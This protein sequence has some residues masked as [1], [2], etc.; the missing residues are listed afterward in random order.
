MLI[1]IERQLQDAF[2]ALADS[3]RRNGWPV[4]AIEHGL[5]PDEIEALRIALEADLSRNRGLNRV[6]VLVWLVMAAEV[7]YSYNGDEYWQSFEQKIPSWRDWGN[8]PALKQKFLCFEKAYSGFRPVGRWAEHF[9]IIS[10]P[11]SH[12]IL[13]SALHSK[14]AQ[15]LHDTRF[16]FAARQNWTDEELGRFASDSYFGG[17]TLLAGLLEQHELTG[18]LISNLRNETQALGD[19]PIQPEVMQRLCDDIQSVRLGKSNLQGFRRVQRTTSIRVKGGLETRTNSHSPFDTKEKEAFNQRYR[20]KW[21][22]KIDSEGAWRL[23][24]N[25]QGIAGLLAEQGLRLREMLGVKMKFVGDKRPSPIEALRAFVTKPMIEVPNFADVLA[26]PL[27][28]FEGEAEGL[29]QLKEIVIG[30]LMRTCWLLRIQ[31]DGLAQEVMGLHIKRRSHYLLVTQQALPPAVCTQLDLKKVNCATEGAVAY[32]LESGDVITEHAKAELKKLGLGWS[33]SIDVLPVGLV[34]RWEDGSSSVV[35]VQDEKVLLH[36]DSDLTVDG[37]TIK[38]NSNPPVRVN[39]EQSQ[40]TLLELSDLDIG[41]HSVLIQPVGA[42]HAHIPATELFISV[43][44]KEHWSLLGAPSA[45]FSVEA[46]PHTVSFED[47]RSGASVL[48]VNGLRG[49][50]CCVSVAFFNYREDLIHHSKL[51]HMKL[52]HIIKSDDVLLER[53][54]ED[55]FEEHLQAASTVVLSFVLSQIGKIGRSFDRELQPIRWNTDKLNG[56]SIVRLID[57]T[58]DVE[59]PALWRASIGVPDE[60]EQVEYVRVCLGDEISAPGYMYGFE[61]T[62]RGLSRVFATMDRPTLS[63]FS[64]LRPPPVQFKSTQASDLVELLAIYNRWRNATFSGLLSMHWRRFVISEIELHTFKLIL[65][66][67]WV[68]RM[69]AFSKKVP[70]LLPKQQKHVG[71]SPGFASQIQSKWK[72]WSRFDQDAIDQFAAHAVRYKITRDSQLAKCAYLLAVQPHKLDLESEPVLDLLSRAGESPSLWKG[73]FFAKTVVASHR[74]S[75]NRE[76]PA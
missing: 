31:A 21:I 34:P 13:A 25:L 19:T 9:S 30:P 56:K 3:R 23:G 36:I 1:E 44:S 69:W 55:E 70:E 10:W 41:S 65:N 73:A 22:A 7:G 76:K 47:I 43:R 4:F 40:N 61:G 29:E 24:L 35:Y 39:T 8:R 15:L 45:G 67:T 63:A 38:I 49:E 18:N 26:R 6:H 32:I 48:N 52:P 50:V 5:R 37:F 42:Q 46:S 68:N 11:I 28:S 75:L 58:D 27:F 54:D 17:S 59:K 57:E 33:H 12:A 64:Q 53:L 16:E 14:F 66:E 51:G 2:A 20:P 60:R 74:H 71:G 62:K 72:I